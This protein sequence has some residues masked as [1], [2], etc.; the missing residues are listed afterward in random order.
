MNKYLEAEKWI[1]DRGTH[2]GDYTLDRIEYLLDELKSPQREYAC[3]LIGGTN[4]KGSVTAI[5]ESILLNCEDYQIGSYT[6]PHL[7]SLRERIKIQGEPVPENLVVKGVKEIKEVTKLMDKEPSIGYPAFFEVMTALGFWALRES[8]TDIALVEVGL[9]GRLDSTNACEP[10]ISVITNIGTDHQQYLGDSK[11]KIAHEKLG[12]IRKNRPLITTEKDPAILEIFQKECDEKKA[13]LVVIKANYGFELIESTKE[14][15]KIKLPFA[16]EAIFFPMPGAHQLE[17]LSLVMAI[18]EQMRKNGFEIPDEAIVKGIKNAHWDGRLQWIKGV[19]EL[20]LDGAHNNEGLETLV[21]YLNTYFNNESLNIIFG[22]L[23][24]KPFA[25]MAKRL[26]PFGNKLCF[27]PP[28][29]PRRPSKEDFEKSG[30][31]EKWQWFNDYK[32]AFEACMADKEHKILV[33]GSL[34]LISDALA[35][36]RDY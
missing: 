22:A 2:K 12:I 20:L 29:C 7:L 16:D 8:D 32:S 15:H 19:P 3:I 4:G 9:G 36:Q 24:D 17:N 33:C 25:E 5:T 14:G 11:D 21:A 13:K 18:I 35:I 27:V 26:E 30:I 31:S 1:L 23:K 10:E 6:S 34:Y 28:T